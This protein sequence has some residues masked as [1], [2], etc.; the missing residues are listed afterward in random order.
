MTAYRFSGFSLGGLIVPKRSARHRSVCG[1]LLTVPLALSVF[2]LTTA[3]QARPAAGA[4][5]TFE[6]DALASQL[7]A[8]ALVSG[9]ISVSLVTFQFGD[10]NVGGTPG[11]VADFQGTI[12][13]R[14]DFSG[15]TPLNIAFT[16][17]ALDAVPSNVAL[18]GLWDAT[19]DN[20]FVGGVDTLGAFQETAGVPTEPADYGFKITDFINLALRDLVLNLEGASRPVSGNYF[21]S[22]FAIGVA[23]A[24]IDIDSPLLAEH[25]R[26][27]GGDRFLQ[28]EPDLG[29]NPAFF[30]DEVVWRNIDGVAADGSPEYGDI[31]PVGPAG[32]PGVVNIEDIGFPLSAIG[33]PDP[34]VIFDANGNPLPQ[35]AENVSLTDSTLIVVGTNE[36]EVDLKLTLNVMT[37]IRFFANQHLIAITLS[38]QIVANAT[39]DLAPNLPG[40]ANSDG[41]V[42]GLDYLVWA[43][44]FGDNP[45]GDP[46]GSPA[47]GDLNNDGA[48]DG[49][50]YLVWAGNFGAS[51]SEVAVPEPSLSTL[52]APAAMIVLGWRRSRRRTTA[53]HGR[54]SDAP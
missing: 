44:N 17:G 37:T 9:G 31:A 50:D 1:R 19:G 18:P 32:W 13:S 46:P 49:R 2:C 40:D 20:P 11:N 4:E 30:G 34:V 24:T 29:E 26:T 6:L 16:A 53:R 51:A 43:E 42:D 27:F 45:A 3:H 48:V 25:R 5:V 41:A 21:G 15:T 54:Q 22:Q 28:F 36:N 52:C 7:N 39:V 23:N 38:G 33:D 8:S 14:V 10:Q 12:S 47:N 35:M